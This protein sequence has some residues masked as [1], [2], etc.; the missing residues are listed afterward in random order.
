M[1]AR[2]AP[3]FLHSGTSPGQ[4]E[5]LTLALIVLSYGV[6]GW[7]TSVL[8]GV[9]LVLAIPVAAVAVVLYSS[10]Q[11]EV[12]HGHP[13][14][15]QWF[16]EALVFPALMVFVPYIR[17]R[18]THL[19]HHRDE[20]LTDPYDDPESNYFDPA[21]WVQLTPKQRAVL[22][23]NNTLLGRMLLGPVISTLGFCSTELRAIWDGDRAIGFAWAMHGVGVA[24]VVAWLWFWGHMPVWAYVAAGY[25]A[26][27]VLKIRTFLEH[28]AHARPSA[29]TVIV[30]D[31]G[32]LSLLFLNNNLH[33]VHHMHPKIAWYRLPALYRARQA[34]YLAR[35]GGYRYASYRDV[36]ARYLLRAKDPV[37]H[38]LMGPKQK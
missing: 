36:F 32:L 17:F 7:A 22:R 33:V 11:H 10:L 6:F 12:L 19:A 37:P 16:N 20:Y 27:C 18:E 34:Q 5:W 9:S 35:N 38:P 24:L 26:F 29:R 28:R 14:P 15:W 8:A 4:I 13:T 21:V 25:L 3:R 30:E 2:P 23:A 1:S 31:R